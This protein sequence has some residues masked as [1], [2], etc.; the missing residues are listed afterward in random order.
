MRHGDLMPINPWI[1]D[2]DALF[3]PRVARSSQGAVAASAP[4]GDTGAA[5]GLGLDLPHG[6]TGSPDGA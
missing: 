4:F 2:A 1:G 6:G 5:T 3:P